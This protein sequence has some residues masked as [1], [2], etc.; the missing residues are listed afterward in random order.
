MPEYHFVTVWEIETPIQGVWEAIGDPLRWPRWW[1]GVIDVTDVS[2]GDERCLGAVRRY[3][4]RSR[5]PYNLVFD[6]RTT[7]VDPPPAIQSVA[8]GELA[9]AGRGASSRAAPRRRTCA[10]NGISSLR[11]TG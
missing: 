11:S 3:T 8:S 5:L 1:R 2:A 10:T 7:L 4:W 9:G 6:M